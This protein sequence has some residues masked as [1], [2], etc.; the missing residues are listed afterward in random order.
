[1]LDKG[2]D[3]WVGKK[4]ISVRFYHYTQKGSQFKTFEVVLSEIFHLIFL[5][6]CWLQV[7]KTVGSETTDKGD[8]YKLLFDSVD[9]SDIWGS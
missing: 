8:Y 1:M 9:R 2:M 3:S 7:T 6:H 5:Y 4:Q